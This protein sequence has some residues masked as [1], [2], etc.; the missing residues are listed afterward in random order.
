MGKTTY[1]EFVCDRCGTL[2]RQIGPWEYPRL[3][4]GWASGSISRDLRF[5]DDTGP[6][7]GG[8]YCPECASA[9]RAAM[10]PVGQEAKT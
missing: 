5:T 8:I 4:L 3:P 2:D 7:Y 10:E 1:T 6:A 9:I